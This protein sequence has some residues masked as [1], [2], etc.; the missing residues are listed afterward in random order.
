M[1][2]SFEVFKFIL[3]KKF[4]ILA[5]AIL[6]CHCTAQQDPVLSVFKCGNSAQFLK[7]FGSFG[8]VL[9]PAGC[10][11]LLIMYVVVYMYVCMMYVCS[12]YVHV[13]ITT[14]LNSSFGRT[15]WRTDGDHLTITTDSTYSTYFLQVT[16]C[17][18]ICRATASSI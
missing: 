8:C 16:R 6:H 15:A 5:I 9:C 13:C 3:E 2:S 12:M 1:L 18:K 14:K 17:S 10:D 4:S 11:V 7:Q